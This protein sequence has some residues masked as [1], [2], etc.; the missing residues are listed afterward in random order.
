M[1]KQIDRVINDLKNQASQFRRGGG[2]PISVGIVGINHAEICAGYEGDRI[3]ETTGSGKY[4]HPCQEAEEAESRLR[5]DAAPL[6]SEFLVLRYSA[7]NKDPFP[8]E[9]ENQKSTTLDYAATLARISSKYQ[10]QF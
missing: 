9:W 3:F 6:F 5:A 1:I 7:T 2:N 4:R 10:Q 8:F